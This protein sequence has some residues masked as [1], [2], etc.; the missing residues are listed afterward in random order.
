MAAP[1]VAGCAALM[2]QEIPDLD[3][4][5]ISLAIISSAVD[6]S[7]PGYDFNAGYGRLDAFAAL[8]AIE[9]PL[10]VALS[11]A[12]P[13]LGLRVSPNPFRDEVRI[14]YS[15]RHS[16]SMLEILDVQGR[17]VMKAHPVI[18]GSTGLVW[19]GRNK[20]GAP[21]P[22][23]VYFVRITGAAGAAVETERLIMVR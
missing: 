16:P 3:Y 13:G 7:T 14:S 10:Q 4:D 18:G 8:L 5:D 19:D 9:D 22:A 1:H 17:R 20:R 11:P 2:L 6:V 23:G 12:V 15:P 21:L